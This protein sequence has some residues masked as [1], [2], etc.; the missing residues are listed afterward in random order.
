MGEQFSYFQD[1]LRDF[2]STI[3]QAF[4][5]GELIFPRATVNDYLRDD[6]QK[7]TERKEK[8]KEKRKV[9]LIMSHSTLSLTLTLSL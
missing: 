6:F 5:E 1:L 7:Q 9:A 8:K 2:S 4:E 3:G